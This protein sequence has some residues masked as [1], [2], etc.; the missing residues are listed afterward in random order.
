[1]TDHRATEGPYR[2]AFGIEYDGQPFSGWQYQ[3]GACTVQ[4]VVQESLF[5]LVAEPVVTYASGRT[6]QGVHATGQVFHADFQRPYSTDRLRRGLNAHFG[7]WPLS[8]WEVHPVPLTF[9][10]RFSAQYRTYVYTIL[11]RPSPSPLWAQ[12][13]WWVA[14]PLDVALVSQSSQTFVGYRDFSAFRHRD[15]QSV[16]PWKTLDSFKVR[17]SGPWV[18]LTITARSFLHRQVRMMVG[19]LISLGLHRITQAEFDGWILAPQAQSR[20][21]PSAPAHGLYLTHVDFGDENLFTSRVSSTQECAVC[22]VLSSTSVM[23]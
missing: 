16:S 17:T 12:R 3:Q 13:A 1:M 5:K 15:C 9:H 14:Q 6:D 8:I 21:A 7:D 10:A 23:R 11:N 18:H 20:K 22:D 19:A 2:Y 4:H